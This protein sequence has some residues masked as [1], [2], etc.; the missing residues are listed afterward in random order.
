MDTKKSVT[1]HQ[2]IPISITRKQSA[3]ADYDQIIATIGG[4]VVGSVFA[5]LTSS[6]EHSPLVQLKTFK[7]PADCNTSHAVR[8]ALLFSLQQFYGDTPIGISTTEIS[9]AYAFLLPE[10]LKKRFIYLPES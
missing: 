6:T 7:L 8:Q 4:K 10:T 2:H 3:D 1:Y 5:Q 9:P